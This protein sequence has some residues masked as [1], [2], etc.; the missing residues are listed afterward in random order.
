VAA[1]AEEVKRAKGIAESMK[2]KR[3]AEGKKLRREM[4]EKL[5]EAE[6][7]REEILNRGNGREGVLE[8]AEE[9]YIAT[10]DCS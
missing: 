5:A 7:R 4:E 3:E 9:E 1:C 6:R 2:E 10:T 8:P